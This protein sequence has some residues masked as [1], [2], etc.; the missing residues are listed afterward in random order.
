M[1]FGCKRLFLDHAVGPMISAVYL[2]DTQPFCC[3]RAS[4]ILAQ[5]EAQKPGNCRNITSASLYI[6]CY[7]CVVCIA[8][9]LF[10]RRHVVSIRERPEAPRRWFDVSSEGVTPRCASL[11]VLLAGPITWRNGFVAD[12]ILRA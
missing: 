1:V 11:P 10:M 8:L 12:L 9:G 5:L 7:C 2:I 4:A 3:I 6:A